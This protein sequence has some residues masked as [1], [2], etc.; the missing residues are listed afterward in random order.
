MLVAGSEVTGG[1]EGDPAA[2]GSWVYDTL[3]LL[4]LVSS[5][6]GGGDP[7]GLGSLTYATCSELLSELDSPFVHVL[8]NAATIQP[9]LDG[10]HHLFKDIAMDSTAGLEN[11]VS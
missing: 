6:E 7:I 10:E 9:L 1:G 11:F 8:C 4:L 2:R 3:K 5:D